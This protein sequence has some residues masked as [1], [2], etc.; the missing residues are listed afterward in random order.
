M[1]WTDENA[2]TDGFEP[3]EISQMGVSSFSGKWA[4]PSLEGNF[5]FEGGMEGGR[6]RREG[7]KGLFKKREIMACKIFQAAPLAHS[8]PFRQI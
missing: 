1:L 7:R 4:D 6:G 5:L 3:N 2:W 8:G